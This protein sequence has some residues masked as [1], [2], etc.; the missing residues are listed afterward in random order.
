MTVADYTTIAILKEEIGN[1]ASGDTTKDDRLS[2]C[3]TDASRVI[4]LVT[5]REEGEFTAVTAT[6][7]FDGTDPDRL[8]I[9]PLNTVTTLKTDDDSDGT[10]E[11]TWTASTDY[12]LY[13]LND[14]PYREI[15]AHP[16]GSYRFPIGPRTI[17]IVGSWG[18]SS[19]P[20]PI[21]R[22]TL[23][24]AARYYQRGSS[25]LGMAGSAETGYVNLKQT[26]PDVWFILDKGGYITADAWIFA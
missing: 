18:D 25:P 11:N 14:T 13:P 7:Y 4:D 20:N 15:L 9:P 3:V 22:A 6:R 23:L 16:T 26:D 10:F 17:Q 12:I 1:F 2:R 19:V 24:L 5:N 21:R 8:V